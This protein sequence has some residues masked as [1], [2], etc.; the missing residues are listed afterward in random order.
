MAIL[1]ALTALTALTT[2]RLEHSQYLLQE[3]HDLLKK[4]L[5]ASCRFF[6]TRRINS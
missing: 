3:L 5:L 4:V 6:S 2:L 1:T